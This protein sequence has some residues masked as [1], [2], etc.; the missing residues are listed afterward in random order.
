MTLF[1][2][3]A[4]YICSDIDKIREQIRTNTQM[5][6]YS[7]MP[8]ALGEI[9]RDMV[10]ELSDEDLINLQKGGTKMMFD[11]CG[12][13]CMTGKPDDICMWAYY[14]DSHKGVCLK[15]DLWAQ[16]LMFCPI[17]HVDYDKSYHIA[18]VSIHPAE[19]FFGDVMLKKADIWAYEDE[20]RTIATHFAGNYPID[21]NGLIAEISFGYYCSDDDKYDIKRIAAEEGFSEMKY[22]HVELNDMQYQLMIKED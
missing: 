12:V 16:P 6:S 11:N 1:E 2:G 9:A 17:S 14:A 15:L 18:D 10:L 21:N 3:Q 22:S 19:M 7:T 5:P 4:K 8:R 20:Y 13:F